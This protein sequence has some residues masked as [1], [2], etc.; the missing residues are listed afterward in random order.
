MLSWILILQN[1]H[2]NVLSFGNVFHSLLQSYQAVFQ[3]SLL[4]VKWKDLSF[5]NVFDTKFLSDSFN[6]LP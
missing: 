5:Y 6:G 1:L 4:G 3:M 2:E